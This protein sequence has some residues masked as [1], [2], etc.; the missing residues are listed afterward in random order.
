M[1]AVA[2]CCALAAALSASTL[3]TAAAG[4]Y[5]ERALYGFSPDGA[6]FAFEEYGVQDGS[7]FPYSNVYVVDTAADTWV[8]GTP[9]RVRIDNEAASLAD[10]R[11]Q[12]LEGARQVLQDRLIGTPGNAVAVNPA[13]ETSANPH[14]VSFRPRLTLPATGPDY[15]LT[16]QEYPLPAADCPE[17]GQPFQG[18]RLTLTT[19]DGQSRVLNEDQSIPASRRCPLSYGISDVVTYYPEPAAAP[20]IVVMV[21]VFSVGFEGPDRRFVAVPAQ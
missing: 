5:A 6:Y 1:I 18:F 10:A 7:G 21:N 17:V 9:V 4:D 13:T 11:S 8:T 15:S 2:R 12:A 19:P 14:F 20:V 3:G 16:I